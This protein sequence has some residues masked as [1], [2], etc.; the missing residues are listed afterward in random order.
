M[1]LFFK[2]FAPLLSP[3]LWPQLGRWPRLCAHCTVLF[4]PAAPSSYR[5]SIAQHLCPDCTA[6]WLP[7]AAT[8]RCP[9]CALRCDAGSHCDCTAHPQEPARAWGHAIAG[10]DH[11]PPWSRWVW[12]IKYGQTPG[13]LLG[14]GPLTDALA[15][16]IER[17]HQTS[18]FPP[19]WPDAVLAMPQTPQR[20]RERGHNQA[21]LLAQAV[22]RRVG[23][24]VIE[25]PVQ[26]L[27]AVHQT[28][29]SRSARWHNAAGA[30]AL[31]QQRAVKHKLAI[32]GRHLAVVDDVMTTGAST[33]ALSAVLLQAGAAS[34]QVWVATRTPAPA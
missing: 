16:A 30:F 34:V 4:R 29:L 13:S 18:L 14:L 15:L 26:R 31:D 32:Q 27:H 8:A 20:W 5:A 33:S 12:G 6:Q 10:A 19:P 1:A 25:G 3:P 17:A 9:H 21:L 28:G 7:D 23:R 11:I 2:R 22:G 24:P